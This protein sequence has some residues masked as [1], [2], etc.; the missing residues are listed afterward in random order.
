[1]HRIG[2]VGRADRMGLAISIVAPLDTNERVWYHSNCSKL[3]SNRGKGCTN[4]ALERD[5]GCTVWLD[6]NQLLSAIEDRLHLELDA[7]SGGGAGAGGDKS[8]T[9][10][11]TTSTTTTTTNNIPILLVP[12]LALPE[13]YS[14]LGISYGDTVLNSN[15]N[16]TGIANTTLIAQNR[17]IDALQG[18]VK[19]LASLEFEV[20]NHFLTMQYT[21]VQGK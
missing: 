18:K 3:N 14:K 4:T 16:T 15:S 17:R 8:T 21:L 11:T 13:C 19:E 10:S 1:M 12:S 6:E 2:R 20:Q 9:A 7:G 5:G